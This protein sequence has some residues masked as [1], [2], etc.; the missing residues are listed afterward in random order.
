[1]EQAHPLVLVVDASRRTRDRVAS[2]LERSGFRVETAASGREGLVALARWERPYAAALIACDMPL[3][4]G[5]ATVAALRRREHARRHTPIIA[6]DGDPA[7]HDRSKCLAAGMDDY[8]A[9]PLDDASLRVALRAWIPA[10]ADQ[11]ARNN[12]NL[13]ARPGGGALTKVAAT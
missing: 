13:I 1:L 11:T 3:L 12:A 2:A 9:M 10:P 5:F 4:D 8:L 7:R 6:I